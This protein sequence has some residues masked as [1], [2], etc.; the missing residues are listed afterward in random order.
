MN[1]EKE[2]EFGW[3]GGTRTEKTVKLTMAGQKSERVGQNCLEKGGYIPTFQV[4]LK[5]GMGER[6]FKQKT[7]PR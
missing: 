1:L 5:H 3:V 6:C 4:K 2:T 7:G